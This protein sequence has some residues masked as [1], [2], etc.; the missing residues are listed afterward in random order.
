MEL[1]ITEVKIIETQQFKSLSDFPITLNATHIS[2]ILGLS[3]AGVYNLLDMEGFPT[4]RVGKRKLVPRDKFI[5]WMEDHT[6]VA[7]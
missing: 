5:E 6:G 4:L 7:I 1:K 3:R 2:Q